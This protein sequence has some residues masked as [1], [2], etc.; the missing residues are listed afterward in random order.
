MVLDAAVAVCAV[1]LPWLRHFTYVAWSGLPLLFACL[2]LLWWAHL[3]PPPM[4]AWGRF[5]P[6]ACA[7][8]VVSV[9]ALQTAVHWL[10][11]TRW[12]ATAL[13][14][15]H[16]VHH[17]HRAPAPEDDQHQSASVNFVICRARH[18]A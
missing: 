3:L 13:G 11:H 16:A 18:S 4:Y 8:L 5:E 7:A 10:A 6:G 17:R 1:N 14:R 12:R 2:G 9:D 15:A